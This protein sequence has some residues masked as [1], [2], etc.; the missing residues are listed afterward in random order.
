MNNCSLELKSIEGFHLIDVSELYIITKKMD[1]T[2]Y[3]KHGDFPRYKDLEK[4]C[5]EVIEIK[6]RYPNWKL[7]NMDNM[8]KQLQ[9]VPINRY[10]YEYK[11]EYNTKFIIEK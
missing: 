5:K 10:K 9:G 7:E 1:K 4:I 8:C 2:D 6:H 3:R 11:D